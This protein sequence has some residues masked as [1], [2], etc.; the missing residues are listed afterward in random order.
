MNIQA[1]DIDPKDVRNQPLINEL[2][3]RNKTRITESAI[4]RREANQRNESR[5]KRSNQK[6]KFNKTLHKRDKRGMESKFK[7]FF[8]KEYRT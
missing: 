8:K 1:S 7:I 2:E 4:I 3:K 5:D 6:F